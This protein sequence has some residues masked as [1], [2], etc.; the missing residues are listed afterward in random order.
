MYHS[1]E[2]SFTLQHLHAV[3]A[4]G[5]GPRELLEQLLGESVVSI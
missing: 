1:Y 4:A 5:S 3:A 2:M